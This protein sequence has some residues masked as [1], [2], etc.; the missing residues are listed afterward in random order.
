MQTQPFI[1]M[2]NFQFER[3]SNLTDQHRK[4]WRKKNIKTVENRS[5]C[6]HHHTRN[7]MKSHKSLHKKR[8]HQFHANSICWISYIDGGMK[9]KA[10][11]RVRMREMRAIDIEI[12][13]ILKFHFF[14]TRHFKRLM[15][16]KKKKKIARP[17]TDRVDCAN[18]RSVIDFFR[19]LHVVE[20]AKQ[21]SKL[22]N[23]SLIIKV[24]WRFSLLLQQK[25]TM[26][27]EELY[28]KKKCTENK[29]EWNKETLE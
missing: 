10:A 15:L 9:R 18:R 29:L 2:A 11:T 22:L 28:R 1:T 20:N 6:I 26:N 19:R 8:L 16:S 12:H 24:L 17:L 27:T 13:I 3:S 23:F 7:V 5:R 21:H 14:S 25:K 4:K